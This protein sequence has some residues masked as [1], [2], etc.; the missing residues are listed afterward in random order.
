MGIG[1][2]SVDEDGRG[3]LWM[4]KGEGSLDMDGGGLRGC[5]WG[6][7]LWMWMEE[8]SV[9]GDWAGLRGYG[10]GRALK[11]G[12][13]LRMGTLARRRWGVGTSRPADREV[14]DGFVRFGTRALEFRTHG[15]VR[16]QNC[17]TK[18]FCYTV[19][20]INQAHPMLITAHLNS[21]EASVRDEGPWVNI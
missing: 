5:G 15:I 20:R 21:G 3:L 17:V 11:M 6:R 7:T 9:D 12:D 16:L 18:Q 10:W 19:R 4:W 14:V 2:G 1:E 8:G 13:P